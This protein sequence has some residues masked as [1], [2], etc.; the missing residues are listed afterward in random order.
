MMYQGGKS[1][2]GRR[3][4]DAITAD[5]GEVDPGCWVEPFAGSAAVATCAAKAGWSIQ[6]SDL[7]PLAC[8]LWGDGELFDELSVEEYHR[9]KSESKDQGMVSA[10]HAQAA[11]S[12]SFAGRRWEG[13]ASDPKSDRN[14]AAAGKRSIEARRAALA[15]VPFRCDNLAYTDIEIPAA[16]LVVVYCDPPY[17]KTTGY[18][19]DSAFCSASFYGWAEAKASQ[20]VSVYVS[21]YTAPD[22]WG[23][24]IW[25]KTKYQTTDVST[26]NG[27][28]CTERLWRVPAST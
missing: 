7:D 28:T 10:A 13:Y 19:V 20:G 16:P 23:A 1:R 26:N 8:A 14:Y 2:L 5:L 4:F 9:L 18:A 25:E 21:E 6:L 17:A 3:I 11:F 15:A 12:C 22:G 24:P 27:K